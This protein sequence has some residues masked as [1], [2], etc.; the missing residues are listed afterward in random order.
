MGDQWEE[1]RLERREKFRDSHR[2]RLDSK[3]SSDLVGHR[4]VIDALTNE[5][6]ESVKLLKSA[7]E[8][9]STAP[10]IEG[11]ETLRSAFA[12][13]V[14]EPAIMRGDTV[15]HSALV[16]LSNLSK[17]F[18]HA[19]S[20]IMTI[21]RCVISL[22]IEKVE[23]SLLKSKVH[24]RAVALTGT[25]APEFEGQAIEVQLVSGELVTVPPEVEISPLAP[26]SM[27]LT[28]KQLE[29][30]KAVQG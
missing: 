14:K 5:L 23:Y 22:N 25:A 6:L 16:E 4:E 2:L 27:D 3:T 21:N 10:N 18:G 9:V 1:Q 11:S 29:N 30:W 28:I 26:V 15:T 17:A 12:K 7:L 8:V 19:I 13:C 20:A 24:R